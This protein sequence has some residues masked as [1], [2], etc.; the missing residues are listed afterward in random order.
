MRLLVLDG[1]RS[2]PPRAHPGGC[3]ARLRDPPLPR[4]HSTTSPTTQTSIATQRGHTRRRL[5]RRDCWSASARGRQDGDARRRAI[6]SPR[7]STPVRRFPDGIAA[8]FRCAQRGRRKRT[9][10][11]SARARAGQREDSTPRA[12]PVEQP[13]GARA[14][15]V[16]FRRESRR[17]RCIAAPLPG[18]RGVTRGARACVRPRERV[19]RRRPR[20]PRSGAPRQ[21]S[22]EPTRPR[23]PALRPPAD[24]STL[25][26]AV[27]EVCGRAVW[28]F[29]HATT[30]SESSISDDGGS[31]CLLELGCPHCAEG[32]A[33][34]T[35]RR[36]G[37]TARWAS[38]VRQPM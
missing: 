16:Q 32:R 8:S 29:E 38:V 4:P 6:G 5:R 2:L 7:G 10:G 11:T 34:I 9:H 37:Q 3:A 13:T 23:A 22:R 14:R 30:C 26:V 31:C 35:P 12:C 27:A 25:A 19:R 17:R 21:L 1:P 18:A 20:M 15:P 24:G 33:S 36:E 28:A